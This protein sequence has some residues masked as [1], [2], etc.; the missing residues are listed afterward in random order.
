MP[1]MGED[2]VVIESFGGG[3]FHLPSDADSGFGKIE[4]GFILVAH[5]GFEDFLRGMV[6]SD[7][8]LA[9]AILRSEG[10]PMRLAL[11][12][13]AA[14][15][16]VLLAACANAPGGAHPAATG[17][18]AANVSPYGMYLA[19]ESAGQCGP[20]RLGLPDLVTTGWIQNG[21]WWY[22]NPGPKAVAA[23]EMWKAEIISP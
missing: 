9:A 1:A 12:L 3:G 23:G 2:A 19:G 14:A 4:V 22:K 17:D 21:L 6:K 8:R 11:L 13:T 10:L 20:C 5:L 15:P 7:R 16:L 18:I